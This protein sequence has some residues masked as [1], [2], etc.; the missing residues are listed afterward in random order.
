MN[1][2][3]PVSIP[4][5]TVTC[6]CH[7]SCDSVT[8][9]VPPLSRSIV[10]WHPVIQFTVAWPTST[11]IQ[12]LTD[13]PQDIYLNVLIQAAHVFKGGSGELCMRCKYPIGIKYILYIFFYPTPLVM[14]IYCRDNWRIRWTEYQ[15]FISVYNGIVID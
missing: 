1:C 2:P 9:G 3:G 4:L 11:P 5:S 12:H 7:T 6:A 10:F 14:A 8:Q 15:N 13:S